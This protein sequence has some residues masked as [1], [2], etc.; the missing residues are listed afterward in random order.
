M[1]RR[2]NSGARGTRTPDLLV[3]NESRYHLRHSPW[4]SAEDIRRPAMSYWLAARR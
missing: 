4:I 1:Y 3:A 2:P